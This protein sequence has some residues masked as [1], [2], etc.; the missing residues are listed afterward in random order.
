MIKKD[1]Y[2][3]THKGWVIIKH[4]NQYNLWRSS[5]PLGAKSRGCTSTLALARYLIEQD[6]RERQVHMIDGSVTIP[7]PVTGPTDS[8]WLS[9]CSCAAGEVVD[10]GKQ[11]FRPHPGAH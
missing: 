11:S 1:D 7:K 10:G 2:T 9:R 6:I 5:D 3:W 4:Y 8:W